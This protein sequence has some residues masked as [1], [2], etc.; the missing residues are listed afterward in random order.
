M[1]DEKDA[2]FPG[3]ILNVKLL[4]QSIK[5]SKVAVL[6]F[7]SKSAAIDKTKRW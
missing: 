2:P 6:I 7:R 5:T 1:K 4:G 3:G